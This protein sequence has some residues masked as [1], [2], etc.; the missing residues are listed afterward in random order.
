MVG[1]IYNHLLTARDTSED[2]WRKQ[3]TI[4]QSQTQNAALIDF[5]TNP[6]LTDFNVLCLRP[7]EVVLMAVLI[8]PPFLSFTLSFPPLLPS[9]LLFSLHT[10]T[11]S[12]CSAFQVQGRAVLHD[13][14]VLCFCV[15]DVS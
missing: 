1:K 14:G 12:M 6:A 8:G 5:M 13:S 2:V 10:H 11:H 3:S 9:F 4:N 7:A 15:E